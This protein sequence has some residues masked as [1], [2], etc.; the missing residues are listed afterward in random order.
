MTVKSRIA[1]LQSTLSSTQLILLSHP[2]DIFYFTGFESLTT[3]RE[4]FLAVT[5]ESAELFLT[6]FS[7]APLNNLDFTTHFL[8]SQKPLSWYLKNLIAKI[9]PESFLFDDDNLT[10]QEFRI[11]EQKIGQDIKLENLPARFTTQFRMIKDE[12]EIASIRKANQLTHQ[13]LKAVLPKLKTGQTEL[14]V[15]RLLENFLRDKGVDIMAFPTIVA[16]GEH[17]ALPHHQPT[18]RKLK[19]NEP[20]LVDIGAKWQN[21]CADVTRTMWFG[22]QPDEKF[23]KLEKIVKDAYQK[24]FSALNQRDEN[25]PLL[26]KDLDHPARSHIEQQGY[27]EKFIHTTGHGV[28]LYIHEQPS[29]N[30]KNDQEIKSNMVI[31]IEPGIYLEGKFGYRFENSVLVTENGA[32]ELV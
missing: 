12:T 13:A 32:E 25:Q 16:F 4:A 17:T 3:E 2:D 7:T 19:M 11:L 29:L 30:W 22:D 20:V 23:V 24:T 28:G 21:Y 9:S 31:T 8:N 1:R 6:A 10:V 14:E 15:E 26:A 18:G 5:K 27:G